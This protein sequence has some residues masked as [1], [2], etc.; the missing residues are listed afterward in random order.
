MD[1]K[2]TFEDDPFFNDTS[3]LY[4]R[5]WYQKQQIWDKFVNRTDYSKG[6]RR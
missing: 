2:D 6:Q 3:M 5:K 4:L 1:A